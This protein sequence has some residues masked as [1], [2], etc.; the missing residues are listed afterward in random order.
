MQMWTNQVKIAIHAKI[1][2]ESGVD[3]PDLKE[4]KLTI[5]GVSVTTVPVTM[6][7]QNYR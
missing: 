1:I 6:N 3:C 7:T 5:G 2:G 4:N